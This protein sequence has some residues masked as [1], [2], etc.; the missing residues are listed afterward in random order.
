MLLRS[1]AA[2][3]MFLPVSSI[4]AG[5]T[6]STN[7]PSPG[8]NVPITWTVTTTDGTQ[9]ASIHIRGG[10]PPPGIVGLP[11]GPDGWNFVGNAAPNDGS[12]A[13][14]D[15]QTNQNAAS[16]AGGWQFTITFDSFVGS[17]SSDQVQFDTVDGNGQ[18][19]FTD[20]PKPPSPN[21]GNYAF[22]PVPEPGAAMA[23]TALPL[24]AARRR[25]MTSG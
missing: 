6:I 7:D 9:I 22:I 4:F 11:Q 3:S 13:N 18:R 16:P 21:R 2:L 10:K 25:R 15:W 24:V 20:I 23:L 1:F 12:N 8:V 14:F 5:V 19:T 17:A